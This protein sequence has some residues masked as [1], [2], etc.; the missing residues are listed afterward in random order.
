VWHYVVCVEFGGPTLAP[1]AGAQAILDVACGTGRWARDLARQL[2]DARVLGFDVDI[3]QIGQSLEASAWRGDD[4]L[5]ANCRLVPGNALDRFPYGD[6]SFDYTHGRFLGA[7]APTAQWPPL[8]GEMIRVTRADG[9]VELL[10]LAR[11]QALS[12]A[13][14]YLL[15]CLRRLYQRGGLRLEPADAFKDTLVR[16][17][18]AHIKTRTVAVRMG[19]GHG[20]HAG[21]MLASDLLSGMLDAAPRYVEQAPDSQAQVWAAVEQ[22]RQEGTGPGFQVTLLAAWGQQP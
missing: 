10:D 20:G 5:P 16:G 21:E 11:I 1:I 15:D 13:Q 4:P 12:P 8:I 18:L 17:G 2:P 3:E 19:G 14:A 6:Q 7:F 9:W 22:A